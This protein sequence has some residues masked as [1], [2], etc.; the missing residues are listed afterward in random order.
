MSWQMVY[1]IAAI[2][3]AGLWLVLWRKLPHDPVTTHTTNY[4]AMIQTVPQLVKRYPVLRASAVNGFV[5]F[6]VSNIFWAI[7]HWLIIRVEQ[8][9]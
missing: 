4:K 8:A 3:I 5:L 1:L 9:F 7:K 6:G 2:L